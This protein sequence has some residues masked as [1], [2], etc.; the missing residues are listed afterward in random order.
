MQS[1]SRGINQS[2]FKTYDYVLVFVGREYGRILMLKKALVQAKGESMAPN[3]KGRIIH[4]G[5]YLGKEGMEI[6][7][8]PKD[9][10]GNHTR[11]NWNKTTSQIK[12]RIR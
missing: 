4:L 9:K 2:I 5:G 8:A 10:D 11:A 12:V 7:D 3:G 1:R 6:V